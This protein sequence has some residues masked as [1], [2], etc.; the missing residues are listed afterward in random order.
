M[1]GKNFTTKSQKKD[2]RD[3]GLFQ[4]I[5]FYTGLEFLKGLEA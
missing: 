4:E 1:E 2:R 3:C 5:L